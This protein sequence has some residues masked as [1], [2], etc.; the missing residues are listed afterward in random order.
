[1]DVNPSSRCYLFILIETNPL[2]KKAPK[3]AFLKP[4]S[5]LLFIYFLCY[6]HTGLKHM[7][8][9]YSA[10]IIDNTFLHRKIHLVQNICLVFN[11]KNFHKLN[12]SLL[13][14]TPSPHKREHSSDIA[15]EA[16]QSGVQVWTINNY[17]VCILLIIVKCY[18]ITYFN[19]FGIGFYMDY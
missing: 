18:K 15:Q 1:M 16:N 5:W 7:E 9:I 14:W 12:E 6:L 8:A 13:Y 10:L 17:I 19:C 3:L 11:D 4:L 2:C